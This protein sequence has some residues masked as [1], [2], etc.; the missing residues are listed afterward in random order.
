MRSFDRL[1]SRKP[2]PEMPHAPLGHLKR[3]TKNAAT[4]YQWHA[5]ARR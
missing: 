3:D 4:A 2:I 1:R 5:M